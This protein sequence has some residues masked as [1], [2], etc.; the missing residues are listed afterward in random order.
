METIASVKHWSSRGEKPAHT[1]KKKDSFLTL[2]VP[3]SQLQRTYKSCL[4]FRKFKDHF[5]DPSAVA[6]FQGLLSSNELN[7]ILA[8][9]LNTAENAGKSNTLQEY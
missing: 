6:K 8:T 7:V 5:M 2:T 9:T 3:H 1:E 4:S